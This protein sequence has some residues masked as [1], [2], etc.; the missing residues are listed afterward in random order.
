MKALEPELQRLEESAQ[1]AGA[2]GA[3]WWSVLLAINEPLSK[4][5]GRGAT[6]EELQSARAYETARAA[7]HQAWCQ[8]EAEAASQ[9][10]NIVLPASTTAVDASGQQAF[11]PVSEPYR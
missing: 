4:L 2:N 3:D 10:G 6:R 11:L 8:G 1:F 5:T 9:A 7:L